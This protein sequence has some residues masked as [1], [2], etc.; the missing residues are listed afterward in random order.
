MPARIVVV[1]DEP[2]FI[3]RTVAALR[4]AGHA[5]MAFMSSMSAI[6]ALENARR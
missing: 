4:A 2:E 1:H 5:V 3:D 6:D